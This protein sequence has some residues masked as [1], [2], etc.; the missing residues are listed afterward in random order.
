MCISVFYAQVVGLWLF[1][2]ALAM[3]VHHGRFKKTVTETLSNGSL[4]TFSGLIGLGLGL[5][6]VVSHNIWVPAW[7]V[8]VTLF[9][10]FL[11]LQG[12]MRVFWP[13]IFAKIMKDLLAGS[14]YTV[15]S[16]IWLLVGLYLIYA[17]FFAL[18]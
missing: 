7:P 13:E 14:G 4:M 15:M 12:L 3:I 10:W 8:I 6:L 5:L 2:I 1:L 9:G 16:W 17:G 11:L 18:N